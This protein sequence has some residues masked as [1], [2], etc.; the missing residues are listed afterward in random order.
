V[1]KRA[2]ICTRMVDIRVGPIGSGKSL[3]EMLI[4]KPCIGLNA[5]RMTLEPCTSDVLPFDKLK[6][7][8]N[9]FT[10]LSP[11]LRG[12]SRLSHHCLI[13]PISRL[14]EC[15][16]ETVYQ[17]E[18]QVVKSEIGFKTMLVCFITGFWPILLCPIDYPE[19]TM[20][21]VKSVS[22]GAPVN[23]TGAPKLNF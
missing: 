22:V 4:G 19:G 7:N 13:N 17:V 20:T 15:K 21:V 12:S 23:E 18:H 3:I 11:L 2:N 6:K 9:V 10:N 1:R 8:G 16:M 5:A 14:F